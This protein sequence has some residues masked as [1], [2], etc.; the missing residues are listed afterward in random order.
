MSLQL[1]IH[2]GGP[3]FLCICSKILQFS[4]KMQTCFAFQ[5]FCF[6]KLIYLGGFK[7]EPDI[8]KVAKNVLISVHR[9]CL[10]KVLE[11]KLS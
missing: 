9:R 11:A 2:R 5:F 6:V 8:G 10:P 1:E 7:P 4:R 3:K